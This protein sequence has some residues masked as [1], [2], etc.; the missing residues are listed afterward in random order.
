MNINHNQFRTLKL[1]KNNN[2]AGSALMGGME[3][4]AAA[5]PLVAGYFSSRKQLILI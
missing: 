1:I 5:T 3:L 2:M 4:A